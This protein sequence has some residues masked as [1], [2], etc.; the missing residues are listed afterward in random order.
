[1]RTIDR[2]ILVVEDEDVARQT[3]VEILTREGFN[4]LSAADGYAAFKLLL[5]HPPPRVIILD[6]FLPVMDGWRFLAEFE[7][8]DLHPKPWII[9]TS[10]S[11][12]IGREWAADHGCAGLVRKPIDAEELIGEIRR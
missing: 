2:T 6:M 12:A 1:M 11:L 4:V 5:S 9:I 8:L 10:G 3:L 7:Q